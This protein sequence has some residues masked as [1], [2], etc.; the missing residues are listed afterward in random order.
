MRL[1]ALRRPQVV[2]RRVGEREG[3]THSTCPTYGDVL[4]GHWFR[5]RACGRPT[6]QC[7][8]AAP[9]QDSET[10]QDYLREA[11]PLREGFDAVFPELPGRLLGPTNRSGNE[12]HSRTQRNS[13]GEGGIRTRRSRSRRRPRRVF[14]FRQKK[15][16]PRW[17]SIT[18]RLLVSG[19]LPDRM[20]IPS[21]RRTSPL[22]ARLWDRMVSDLAR[23]GRTLKPGRQTMVRA[24][25]LHSWLDRRGET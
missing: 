3:S 1:D 11:E 13:C 21:T 4:E 8:S 17:R 23:E 9:A 6:E 19:S 16:D 5:S 14:A 10:M 18:T 2:D 25:D 24:T 12:P 7:M 20:R 22:E 15:S